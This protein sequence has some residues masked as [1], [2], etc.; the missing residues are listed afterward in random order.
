MLLKIGWLHVRLKLK[1]ATELT[2]DR[3]D[4]PKEK[5]NQFQD[6]KEG[7]FDPIFLSGVFMRKDNALVER[8]TRSDEMRKILFLV[9]G[10]SLILPTIYAQDLLHWGDEG[11]PIVTESNAQYEQKIIVTPDSDIF[12]GWVDN[13]NGNSDRLIFEDDIYLQRLDRNGNKYWQQNGLP[14]AV[15]SGQQYFLDMIFDGDDGVILAWTSYNNRKSKIYVQRVDRNG[16]LRWGPEGVLVN[17][18]EEEFYPRLVSDGRGGA[19]IIWGR[20]SFTSVKS[21]QAQHISAEGNLLWPE[22]GI[23]IYVSKLNRFVRMPV[24]VTSDNNGFMCLLYYVEIGSNNNYLVAQHL[25]YDGNKV[26]GEKGIDI[27]TRP[28]FIDNYS[29][30]NDGEGGAII[31]WDLMAQ[32]INASGSLLWGNGKQLLPPPRYY[33]SLSQNKVMWGKDGNF[34]FG[35]FF[36]SHY[37]GIP[38]ILDIQKFSINGDLLW[39]DGKRAAEISTESSDTFNFDMCQDASGGL[40]VTWIDGSD[41]LH[42]V[43]YLQHF[44]ERGDKL[45]DNSLA[46]IDQIYAS[47]NSRPV[48]VADNL[49]GAI[50]VWQD[51]RNIRYINR[52][53]YSQRVYENHAPVISDIPDQVINEGN[54]LQFS[55][56]ATD[57]DGDILTY[58]AS[59]L[60]EGANFDAATKTFTWTPDY[61]QAGTYPNIKFTVSDGSLTDEETIIITVN[62]TNRGPIFNPIGN[63]SVNEGTLLQFTI[64]AIDPD[65]DTVTYSAINLPVGATID[66]QT[67]KFNWTPGYTQAGK[68]IVTFIASDGTLSAGET[69]TIT[70]NNINGPPVFEPIGDKTINRLKLLRFYIRATDPDGDRIT[71][72]AT[73]LPWGAYFNKWTGMFVWVPRIWQA[74]DFRVTFI[75]K[76]RYG[77]QSSKTITISVINR[78]P[79]LNPIGD[80]TIQARR[81]LIFKLHADDPD[82]IDRYSLNYYAEGLPQGAFLGKLGGVFIWVPKANQRGV[83]R[84]RFYV[85]DPPGAIDDET[86]TITVK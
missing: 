52:D 29:I 57:S 19:F 6:V 5:K 50:V 17:S 62:N 2:K 4:V 77:H 67:G 12:V 46:L 80:K 45:L 41:T 84:V 8:K 54:L 82:I 43:P 1:F 35:S 72:D 76:D 31:C 83:Y 59:N 22:E 30:I 7:Q 3:R 71:Y 78:A 70:V 58:S 18:G 16:T 24:A 33:Y 51:A 55:V 10:I 27:V 9:L 61:D 44:N 40:F 75:A 28:T 37:T 48:A 11:L 64:S 13:R 20:G 69:I 38:N 73:N 23:Q 15:A 60:P 63:K 86:I 26:W 47:Y 68:Y 36:H 39:G 21:I 49:G 85:K 42:C 25:D 32:R 53:I 34:L 56:S 65:G 81:L 79:I 66:S 74:G 14:L